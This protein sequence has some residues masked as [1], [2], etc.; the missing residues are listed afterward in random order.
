MDRL[1]LSHIP[2]KNPLIVILGPTASGKTDFSLQIWEQLNCEIISADSRQVYKYLDIGTAKPSKSI[3]TRYK[4]H[5]IDFLE[6]DQD[7]SAG[8]FVSNSK[9]IIQNLYK[10]N[11]IPVIV[12]GTGL[13]IDS[14]CNRFIELPTERIDTSIREK[15]SNDL[16]KFG[17]VYLY[18]LL[19]KIDPESASKYPDMNPRRIIRALEFYYQS[20][21]KFSE[22]QRKYTKESEYSVFYF[23]ID[24]SREVLYERINQRSKQMWNDGII[25]ETRE[26]LNRGY[27]PHLNSLNTVGYK[28]VINYLNGNMT[29]DQALEE[30]MKNTRHYAKRQLTWFRKNQK[31][32]WI[33]P[34]LIDKF[35][36]YDFILNKK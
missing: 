24:F 9:E 36:I 12:G 26:I 25:E 22:A 7:F 17:K 35:I 6:P 30:M 34:E 3:L 32:H 23:G 33:A 14:L 20:G 4:H 2:H 18:E 15:L 1:N 28:E 11:K 19:N 27:S 21:I 16:D 8:H 13:Y 5:L 29:S 10:Q 31:I